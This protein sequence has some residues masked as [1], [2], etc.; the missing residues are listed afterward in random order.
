MKIGFIDKNDKSVRLLCEGLRHIELLI[1]LVPC[2]AVCMYT[3]PVAYNPSVW[4]S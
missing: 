1:V 2:V 4:V 3:F